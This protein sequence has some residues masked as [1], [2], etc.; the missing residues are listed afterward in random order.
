M[1]EIPSQQVTVRLQALFSRDEPQHQRCF[2]VLA[3][4][5]AGRVLTDDLALP[6]WG[7][8]WEAGDGTLYLG[9]AVTG[10]LL[11]QA[12]DMLR[13]AGDV[14]LGLWPD[15]PRWALAPPNPDYTGATIDFDD[16]PPGEGL[17]HF[18]QQMP[19]DCQ[20]VRVD[21]RL[22]ARARWYAALIRQ[23]GSVAGFFDHALGKDRTYQAPTGR[24]VTGGPPDPWTWQLAEMF[25]L[26]KGKIRQIEAILHRAPYGMNSG[27]STWEDGLSSGARD[28]TKSSGR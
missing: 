7:M 26:E 11:G 2:A 20:V 14:L 17:D 15:D 21:E 9:G 5:A 25:K 3:G 19:A 12:V 13:R 16:R 22:L 18:V 28:V 27:W 10:P 8:V 23:F 24:T 4:H 1:I 6:N